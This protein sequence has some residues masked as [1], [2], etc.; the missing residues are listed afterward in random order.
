MGTLAIVFALV[1][2]WWIYTTL[3]EGRKAEAEI[4]DRK[5]EKTKN[6]SVEEQRKR[7]NKLLKR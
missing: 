4:R 2:I 7:L 3:K 6:A 1:S 5:I